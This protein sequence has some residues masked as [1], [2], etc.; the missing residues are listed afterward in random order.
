MAENAQTL[1]ACRLDDEEVQVSEGFVQ[2]S[3]FDCEFVGHI[4]QFYSGFIPGNEKSPVKPTHL[5]IEFLNDVGSYIRQRRMVPALAYVQTLRFLTYGGYGP[6]YI[7][8][9]SVTRSKVV[10]RLDSRLPD[11]SPA[12]D[13]S[14]CLLTRVTANSETSETFPR[15]SY[16]VQRVVPKEN[17][18]HNIGQIRDPQQSLFGL[19]SH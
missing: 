15:V 8:Y 6:L 2:E 7:F 17:P 14:F 3:N 1:G 18:E 12:C 4:A 16:N 11:P 10:Q 9:R 13:Q 5:P 19:V